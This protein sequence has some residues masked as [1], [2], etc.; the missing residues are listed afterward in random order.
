M[1]YFLDSAPT[2]HLEED[3]STGS[4]SSSPS[5]RHSLDVGDSPR[6]S[7]EPSSSRRNDLEL[8]TIRNPLE[9]ASYRH[10]F[11]QSMDPPLRRHNSLAH[12]SSFVSFSDFR[13]NNSGAQS[14]APVVDRGIGSNKSSGLGPLDKENTIVPTFVPPPIVT[15]GS[16]HHIFASSVLTPKFGSLTPK[17]IE[18]LD[19]S[20]ELDPK[21]DRRSLGN[22]LNSFCE[23][24]LD[25][26]PSLERHESFLRFNDM[27]SKI[28][29][30]SAY[31]DQKKHEDDLF[32]DEAIG[33]FSE[34][35]LDSDA[36][37]MTI[38]EMGEL[39]NMYFQEPRL[40]ACA[41][42]D[43]STKNS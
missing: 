42:M 32:S 24:G 10:Y 33:D 9:P 5:R 35:D 14:I 19:A 28:A 6:H 36:S 12:F 38:S 18:Y 31:F 20:G 29:S 25:N 26:L 40:Q 3:A 22:K 11:D 27:V 17:L 1:Q 23:Y 13:V 4:L 15:V 21:M 30:S 16:N 2:F 41:E 43:G 7:L 37:L 34:L 8:L 39:A